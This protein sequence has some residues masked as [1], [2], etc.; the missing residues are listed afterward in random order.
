MS[1][2]INAFVICLIVVFTYR[3]FITN[4]D[5]CKYILLG[6]ISFTLPYFYHQTVLSVREYEMNQ[7]LPIL[8]DNSSRWAESVDS[9]M[10]NSSATPFRDSLTLLCTSIWTVSI[11]G[12]I[13]R[14]HFPIVSVNP[15]SHAFL[16]RLIRY[17]LSLIFTFFSL[18]CQLK[19]CYILSYALF[20]MGIMF[21][22]SGA[23]IFRRWKSTSLSWLISGSLIY[24]AICS[25][26]R[27]LAFFL[28]DYQGL[29]VLLAGVI[30][31]NTLDYL[32]TIMNTY[33]YLISRNEKTLASCQNAFS[34]G[35]WLALFKLV[36]QMPSEN[37]L[38]IEPIQDLKTALAALGPASRSWKTM[39]MLFPSHLR[40]DLCLLYAFFRQA[41]D[42]VDN[43]LTTEAGK[44]SLGLLRRFFK[45]LFSQPTWDGPD[46]TL[47]S[48]VDWAYYQSHLDETSLAI[49]RNVARIS[50][51]LCPRAMGELTEAWSLDLEG[52]PMEQ[53][54]DLLHYAALISGTFGELC[55]CLI[56]Y[57]TGRGNWNGKD[58]FV[59]QNKVL[60]RARATGQCLQLINIARD[61]VADSIEGRCYVPLTYM[62]QPGPIYRQLKVVRKPRQLGEATLKSYAIRILQLADQTSE[63][64]QRGINGLPEEVQDSIRAAFDIYRA[65]GPVLLKD[66]EFPL[67]AKVPKMQQQAIAFRSLY[68]F[69]GPVSHFFSSIYYQVVF[70]LSEPLA[71]I[72]SK[73]KAYKL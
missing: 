60:E 42:L 16:I 18:Y 28:N 67:R 62:A 2:T 10:D 3:P 11:C 37:D 6:S 44:T 51:Y 70:F 21:Y 69:H 47:P 46:S 40:Q 26:P 29:V 56:M 4:L 20:S 27:I 58:S 71:G 50:H 36:S 19:A 31:C 65:I 55:T 41:D 72:F 5:K 63:K 25:S 17:G 39:A 43:T 73:T 53:Q 8:Q 59:R 7:T 15:Q 45:E 9:V 22:L 1:M 24:G 33:P 66:S 64:A 14:W 23:Y 57:K 35:Y 13:S 12:L 52:L 54:K 68:G 32:D 38:P 34:L 48:H 49:F 61:I 30:M